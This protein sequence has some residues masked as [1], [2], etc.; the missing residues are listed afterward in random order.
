MSVIIDIHNATDLSEWT[1]TATDGGDL[2]WQAAAGLGG[3]SGGMQ[4]LIN[5]NTMIYGS[6]DPVSAIVTGVCRFRVYFDP[7]GLSM[8]NGDVF[9]IVYVY[10]TT[11]TVLITVVLT[12]TAGNIT[13]N[14][15]TASDTGTRASTF[16]NITD[17]PHYI[18]VLLTRAATAV[19][20]DGVLSFWLDGVLIG[21]LVNID[22]YDT[23]VSWQRVYNI[24][25]LVD[26]GTRGTFFMDELVVNDDGT[27][28]GPVVPAGSGLVTRKT[29]LGVGK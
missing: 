6:K 15:T 18:E 8:T 20:A 11:A 3:T 22:N 17:E 4:F 24:A 19:S 26:T 23:F 27:L 28:I 2:S 9:N 5:D 12:A 16:T 13:M 1:A 21:S 25:H 10:I 7:N 14:V 29:L